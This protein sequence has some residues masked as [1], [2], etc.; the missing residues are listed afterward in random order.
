MHCLFKKYFIIQILLILG[1]VS[2][3]H[4]QLS[5][6]YMSTVAVGGTTNTEPVGQGIS[7]H[8]PYI[9]QGKIWVFYSDGTNAVVRTKQPEEGGTWSSAQTLF[10]AAQGGNFNTAFDGEYFH[11]IRV[12]NGESVKY[13]RGRAQLNGSIMLD[14]EVEIWNDPVLVVTDWLLSI[15]VDYLKRPWVVIQANNGVNFKPVVLSSVNISGGWQNR[16]GF[17]KDLNNSVSGTNGWWHGAAVNAFEISKGRIL[18]SWFDQTGTPGIKARLWLEDSLNPGGEGSLGSLE[19]TG[20]PFISHLTRTS[21]VSPDGIVVL[22]N[23]ESSVARRGNNGTWVD[24]TPGGIDNVDFNSLSIYNDAIRIWGISGSNIIYKETTN[25]GNS[26]GQSTGKWTSTSPNSMVA[27]HVKGSY[28]NHHAVL[29]RSG[30]S[31]YN[32]N[33]GIEGTKTLPSIPILV[34]PQNGSS[35]HGKDLNFVWNSAILGHKYDLQVS[36]QSDFASTLI[37]EVGITDTSIAVNDLALN[38]DYYWRV[39]TVTDWGRMSDWSAVWT[40]KTVGIP[41]SPLLSSPENGAIDQPSTL[42]LS[43]NETAG[44]ETY[45][46]QISTVSNFSSTFT[47]QNSLTDT[48]YQV[49]GL[50]PERTYY[51]RVRAKN[52][53]GDGN[54]SQVWNFTTRTGIPLPPVLASPEDGTSDTPTTLTLSWEVSAGAGSYRVQVSK[55]INFASTVINIGSIST[56]SYEATNLEHSTT[57][58]WRVNATNASGTSM[59]S[60]IRSFTT[61]IAIPEVPVLVAPVNQAEEISTKPLLDWNTADRAES[62]GLQLATDSTFNNIVHNITSIDSTSYRI[63]DELNA[64]TVYYW[65]INANNISGTSD[66][67][68]VRR[69]T[70]GQA[71]PVAPSLVSPEP[72]TTEVTNTLFLWNAVATATQYHI[73]IS[74]SSDFSSPTIDNNAVVNTFYTTLSLVRFTQYYWRVRAISPVGAGDWSSVWNFTTGDIVSVEQIDNELPTHFALSQNYPNPFNPTT[75]IRFSLPSEV[76]V[77]LEVYNML[78]QRIATLIDGASYHAGNYQYTWDGQDDSGNSVS[79][80]MYI[81]RI[82]AGEYSELKRMILMK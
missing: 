79:S 14:P 27:S 17:P 12:E 68:A 76:S 33:M 80:G 1:I 50:D 32:I 75:S 20:L 2:G 44:A 4:A 18:F 7:N 37:N 49:D 47:D 39:R 41:P 77:R 19:S 64:F 8:G 63:S 61:I 9:A 69:F 34:F 51:W 52:S 31:P 28:G 58:Y 42:I 57:Y 82:T 46:I 43:W 35:D 45:Q 59:W 16:P 10:P 54:W 74:E 40:F 13:R 78:G 73:Q 36:T 55:D 5:L 38:V 60:T 3:L 53:F 26:W 71:F 66:W 21:P 25:N 70:T 67:S 6:N 22:L 62:Y 29:W 24:V 23:N 56:T 81:Y 72:G 30:S 11:F 65:R 15:A 48:S